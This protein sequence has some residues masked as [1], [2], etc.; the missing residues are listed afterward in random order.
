MSNQAMAQY[1]V[2]CFIVDPPMFVFFLRGQGSQ[3][4]VSSRADP[5]RP[6]F[7]AQ[8]SSLPSLIWGHHTKRK[9]KHVL[10]SWATLAPGLERKGDGVGSVLLASSEK[11]FHERRSIESLKLCGHIQTCRDLSFIGNDPVRRTIRV[12]TDYSKFTG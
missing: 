3:N 10:K 2:K 5:L 8:D 4:L 12:A 1:L 9:I 11:A 7:V 6:S